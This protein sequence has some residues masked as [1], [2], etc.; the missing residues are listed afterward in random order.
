M[1][2]YS[3]DRV[4]ASASAPLTAACTSNGSRRNA[5]TSKARIASSSSTTKTFGDRDIQLTPCGFDASPMGALPLRE[6][7]VLDLCN[8]CKIPDG[9]HEANLRRDPGL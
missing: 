6:K 2:A 1:T 8:R 4:S 9:I 3:A 7:V 5:A